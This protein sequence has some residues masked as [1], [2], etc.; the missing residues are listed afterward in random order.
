MAAWVAGFDGYA[1]A[2][3]E[4]G[5]RGADSVDRARGFVAHY[6]RVGRGDA[7]GADAAVEPEVDLE[8]GH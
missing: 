3:G 5:D 4:G 2:R 8:S 7:G 6:Q 1:V